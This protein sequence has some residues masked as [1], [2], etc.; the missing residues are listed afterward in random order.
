MPV[1]SAKSFGVKALGQGLGA[2]TERVDP[3]FESVVLLLHGEGTEGA[4]DSNE[5][6]T[7]S[8][9]AFQDNSSSAHYLLL[10]ADAF[11]NSNLVLILEQMVI[12]QLHL[13]EMPINISDIKDTIKDHLI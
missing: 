13:M 5:T 9:K 4:S 11:G 2:D 6:G 10:M 1:K 12:G 7:P 8:Y 3:D